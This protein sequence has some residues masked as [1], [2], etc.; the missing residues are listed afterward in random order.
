MLITQLQHLS[1]YT[2]I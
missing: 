1:V 2:N